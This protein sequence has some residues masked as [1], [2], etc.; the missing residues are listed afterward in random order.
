MKPNRAII[1]LGSNIEA[2]KNIYKAIEELKNHFNVI[3]VSSIKTNKPIGITNQPDFLNGVVLVLTVYNQKKV[4]ILLKEIENKMGRDRSLPKFGPRIIDLDI[5]FWNN[6]VV[7]DDYY[8][9]EFLQMA[10]AEITS[11]KIVT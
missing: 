2:E 3:S 11:T 8:N 5:L 6:R 7:D 10:V 4:T 9:R 1:S